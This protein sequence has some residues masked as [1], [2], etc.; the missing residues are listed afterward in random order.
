MPTGFKVKLRKG[1]LAGQGQGVSLSAAVIARRKH[2][3]VPLS[4]NTIRCQQADTMSPLAADSR[5][6]PKLWS[7]FRTAAVTLF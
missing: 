1:C 3:K 2:G 4:V 6:S 5:R 7:G